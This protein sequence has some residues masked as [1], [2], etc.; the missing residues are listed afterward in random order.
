MLGIKKKHKTHSNKGVP[1]KKIDWKIVDDYLEAGCNGAQI[2]DHLGIHPDTL[3]IRCEKE[4]EMCFSAYLQIK[5]ASGEKLLAK[6]QFDKALGR[7]KEADN[8]MLIWLGKQRLNQREPDQ[9]VKE[10]PNDAKNDLEK[11][12]LE[13]EY[14]NLKQQEQIDSLQPQTDPQLQ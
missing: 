2:A 11:K 8:T 1:A 14:K 4:K 7:N 9:P 5:R 10:V 6:A 3:Y 13:S 12:L